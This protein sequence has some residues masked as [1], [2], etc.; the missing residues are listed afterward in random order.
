MADCPL[1]TAE[2]WAVAR[3]GAG[4]GE[5]AALLRKYFT[6][7]SGSASSGVGRQ[8]A[9]NGRETMRVAAGNVVTNGNLV[10]PP[11]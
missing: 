8:C 4:P 2:L 9:E 1:H 7:V 5:A 3:S 10:N 11:A 6:E